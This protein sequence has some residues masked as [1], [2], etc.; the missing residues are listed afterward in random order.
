M[1]E[2]A[3]PIKSKYLRFRQEFDSF[4]VLGVIFVV[5]VLSFL[6]I[7]LSQNYYGQIIKNKVETFGINL[8]QK[9]SIRTPQLNKEYNAEIDINKDKIVYEYRSK[10]GG[11]VPVGNSQGDS[12]YSSA[13][14]VV[15][16]PPEKIQG[17]I[18]GNGIREKEEECDRDDF[19]Q[20]YG[21]CNLY[22]NSYDIGDLICGSDCKI[23]T[24]YCG[25]KECSIDSDCQDNL[26]CNGLE[27]CRVGK[28]ERE[29]LNLMD[30]IE[31]T[32]DYCDENLDIIVHENS[33]EKCS[34]G[35][36]CNGEEICNSYL[37][38]VN[39]TIETNDNIYC[40]FDSCNEEKDIVEHK[41]ENDFC[42]N[43]LFCDG[44]E[45]CDSGKGCIKG[46]N[47]CK[48][49]QSCYEESDV[50]VQCRTNADKKP[51]DNCIQKEELDEFIKKYYQDEGTVEDVK[52]GIKAYLQGC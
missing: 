31:C 41:P 32:I 37:G 14:N 16:S 27:F 13:D 40:T 35:V 38:C 12:G 21:K 18:C 20:F 28:C 26:Y 48:T 8:I 36:F 45:I 44:K 17:F 3:Y 29:K 49:D 15:Y 52:N 10:T 4:N 6:T 22:S 39:S 42:S 11:S 43:S 51:C 46:E 19:D 50:C 34:D 9:F 47:S 24:R 7:Y 1:G 25:V 33:N 5:V 30:K 23:D 2:E